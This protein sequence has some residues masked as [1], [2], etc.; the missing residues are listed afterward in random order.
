MVI[1][2]T[3]WV[4]SLT[5]VLAL[6]GSPQWLA[7]AALVNLL[8]YLLTYIQKPVCCFAAQCQGGYSAGAWVA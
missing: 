2:H 5:C 6:F 1:D 4:L 3:W 7:A 8:T